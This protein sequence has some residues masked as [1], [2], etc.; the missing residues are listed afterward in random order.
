MSDCQGSGFGFR[1]PGP[2]TST[3]G[4]TLTAFRD[5]GLYRFYSAARIVALKDPNASA[6]FL[7]SYLGLEPHPWKV[8]VGDVLE[9][10]ATHSTFMTMQSDLM[11]AR[12]PG[13]LRG[14]DEVI[15]ENG[16]NGSFIHYHF[17]NMNDPSR[18]QGLGGNLAGAPTLFDIAGPYSGFANF[19][20]PMPGA[21][22]FSIGCSPLGCAD[23]SSSHSFYTSYG[24]GAVWQETHQQYDNQVIQRFRNG[25]G[26]TFQY[27]AGIRLDSAGHGVDL[28][29]AP[30]H[31]LAPPTARTDAATRGYVDDAA[32]HLPAGKTPAA[33]A[34]PC[35]AGSMW[36]DDNFLYV[37][38]A[39]GTSS[40]RV[41]LSTF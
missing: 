16:A 3:T 4:A 35:P 22:M 8:A 18:Y 39:A 15:G 12:L 29:N 41:A 9:S 5:L 10:P 14:H 19:H 2:D 6:G 17:V 24:N 32:P 34:T 40:K 7:G 1:N 37:C 36:H 25:E 27:G 11:I 21:T 28:M 30:L 26:I 20:T 23:P 13:N 38:N 33:S 31:R